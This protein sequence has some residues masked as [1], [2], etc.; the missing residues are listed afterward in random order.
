MY[1]PELKHKANGI[2]IVSN[3]ELDQIGGHLFKEHGFKLDPLR[4][5]FYGVCDECR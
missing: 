3:K 4:T 5:V 2:P 1:R